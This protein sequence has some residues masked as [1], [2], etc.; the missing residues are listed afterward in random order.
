MGQ[1]ETEPRHSELIKLTDLKG[2]LHFHMAPEGEKVGE[3]TGSWDSEIDAA[4]MIDWLAKYLPGLEYLVVTDHLERWGRDPKR[5]HDNDKYGV[6]HSYDELK[7]VATQLAKIRNLGERQPGIKVI[8]GVETSI[9]TAGTIGASK[10][11]LDMFDL[12]VASEHYYPESKEERQPEELTARLL[13][14][15]SNPGV[16]II[17]HPARNYTDWQL[18]DWEKI[19]R[20]AA[21]FDKAIEINITSVAQSGFPPDPRL[22]PA[23]TLD[24][25]KILAKGGV[26]VSIGSDMHKFWPLNSN[27]PL[28]PGQ[29][30]GLN[31][32]IVD[33]NQAGFK[34]SQI[35]NTYKPTELIGW[36]RAHDKRS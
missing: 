15:L 7:L 16:D 2:D 19:A 6:E 22:E 8:S 35:L 4:K 28:L 11:M 9:Q 14:A 36:A 32:L 1:Q 3:L 25:L 27:S 12:V 18:I 26:K 5:F 13:T 20:V 17:G 24:V 30:F 29:V 33:L 23:R 10:R 31:R 34:K 21:G